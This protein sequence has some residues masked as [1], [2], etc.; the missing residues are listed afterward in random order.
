MMTQ[1]GK[2]EEAFPT[3]VSKSPGCI[4]RN[5]VCKE[6]E[7]RALLYLLWSLHGSQASS[8]VLR[9]HKKQEGQETLVGAQAGPLG[10]ETC[11]C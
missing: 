9:R 6:R 1:G 2:E 3:R 7:V 10:L 8:D 5:I 11:F 4:N